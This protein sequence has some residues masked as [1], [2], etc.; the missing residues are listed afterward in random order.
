M[1]DSKVENT[2]VSKQQEIF[3]CRQ[4]MLMNAN[5]GFCLLHSVYF[6]ICLTFD[7]GLKI[8]I[9]STFLYCFVVIY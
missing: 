4:L 9:G 8:S 2:R 7:M 3:S 6:M 5:N 1:E